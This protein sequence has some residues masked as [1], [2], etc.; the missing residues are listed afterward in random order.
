MIIVILIL[1][2]FECVVMKWTTSELQKHNPLKSIELADIYIT[3]FNNMYDFDEFKCTSTLWEGKIQ[4]TTLRSVFEG[5]TLIDV[6][7]EVDIITKSLIGHQ[8][9]FYK[10]NHFSSSVTYERYLVVYDGKKNKTGILY[11]NFK[12]SD[13]IRPYQK[14]K[15]IMLFHDVMKHDT[16]IFSNTH[17]FIVALIA[18]IALVAL[19][20]LVMMLHRPP[21]DYKDNQDQDKEEDDEEDDDQKKNTPWIIPDKDEKEDDDKKKKKE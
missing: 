14:D 19:V 5:S 12:N 2:V 13:G 1:C 11:I 17:L 4:K 16:G 3:K 9:I 8:T 7:N 6:D 21:F 18:L 10:E 15:I 20:A